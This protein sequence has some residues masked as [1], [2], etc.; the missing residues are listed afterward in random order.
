MYGVSFLYRQKAKGKG[1]TM[2]TNTNTAQVEE[3]A[4]EVVEFLAKFQTI[5]MS[6]NYGKLD[7]WI[8]AD[9]MAQLNRYY[10]IMGKVSVGKAVII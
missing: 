10:E 8:Q 9:V 5:A 3:V 4:R 7:S 2:N 6:E 1:N